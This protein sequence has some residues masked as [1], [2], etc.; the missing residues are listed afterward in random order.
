MIETVKPAEDGSGT[1]VRLYNDTPEEITAKITASGKLVKTDML[2]RG[3]E[4]MSGN[5]TLRGFEI[6]TFKIQS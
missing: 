2:E 4:K 3:G 1:V 6:L 5:I